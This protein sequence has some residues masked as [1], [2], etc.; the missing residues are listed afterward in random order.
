METLGLKIIP[1]NLLE[2]YKNDFNPTLINYFNQLKDSELSLPDFNFYPTLKY[3][4]TPSMIG[5]LEECIKK[6]N[7]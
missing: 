2:Q 4:Q 7:K 1:T 6:M 3:P 5:A